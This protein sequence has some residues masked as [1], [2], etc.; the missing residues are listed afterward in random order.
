MNG[1]CTEKLIYVM[2]WR[3]CRNKKKKKKK[4]KEGTMKASVSIKLIGNLGVIYC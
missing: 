1:Y 4:K 3:Q 2:N